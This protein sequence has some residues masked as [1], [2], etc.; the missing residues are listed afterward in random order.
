MGRA[1]AGLEC[2]DGDRATDRR[3]IAGAGGECSCCIRPT[4]PPVA[5]QTVSPVTAALADGDDVRA[6]FWRVWQ[7]S[8]CGNSQTL[9]LPAHHRPTRHRASSPLVSVTARLSTNELGVGEASLTRFRTGRHDEI[10]GLGLPYK[11]PEMMS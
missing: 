9:R 5:C 4:V 3:H 2:L 6:R 10:W 7:P 8:N 1:G 11:I